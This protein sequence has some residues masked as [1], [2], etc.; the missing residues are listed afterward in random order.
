MATQRKRLTNANVA[1]LRAASGDYTIWDTRTAG[2]GVRVRPTG[3]RTYVYHERR[4]STTRRH[5][6]GSIATMDVDVARAKCRDIQLEPGIQDE[7]TDVTRNPTFGEFIAGEWKTSCLDR[8]KASWRKGVVSALTQQLVPAFGVLRLDQINAIGVAQWFDRY[9]TTAPGGANHALALLRQIMNQAI[10]RGYVRINPTRG[11]KRNP[12]PSL[13]RFLSLDEIRRLHET[14]DQCVVERPTRAASADIVRLLLLTGCR[15]SEIMHLQ[16]RE[17]HGDG[18]DLSDAKTGPRRVFLNP[19]ARAILD[20]Q[21]RSGSPY[22]FP[23]PRDGSRPRA[24]GDIRVWYLVRKR[25]RD[26][27]CTAP[28]PATYS[29]KSR[30]DERYSVADGRSSSRPPPS[31]NDTALHPC[32]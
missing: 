2:F 27:G 23:S 21:P 15:K 17:V 9:S 32:P 12:R 30:R 5:T 6:L 7:T 28:R 13:T 25:G 3:H 19:Q 10:K 1:R 11:I 26:R 22:V 4:G 24:S 8:Y 31:A 20:R 16:W 18:L 29:C 14:L